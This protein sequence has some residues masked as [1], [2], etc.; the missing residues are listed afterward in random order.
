[1]SV[2]RLVGFRRCPAFPVALLSR[3][4]MW[5]SSHSKEPL[6]CVWVQEVLCT[7]ASDDQGQQYTTG[8][9]SILSRSFPVQLPRGSYGIRPIFW[10]ESPRILAVSVR[11]GPSGGLGIHVDC[12][13]Y[14]RL[15]RAHD[16]RDAPAT[17]LRSIE[18]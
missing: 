7:V 17:R 12:Q 5:W 6:P 14:S 1:M 11:R 10:M 8:C 3:H 2:P 4:I 16:P 9:W 18:G 15:L 13:G